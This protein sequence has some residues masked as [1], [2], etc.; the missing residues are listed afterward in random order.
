MTLKT[1]LRRIFKD[2]DKHAYEVI[3][4]I[5]AEIIIAQSAYNNLYRT[6]CD[7]SSK[8]Y[9][10]FYTVLN[11]CLKKDLNG[12]DIQKAL[13]KALRKYPDLLNAITHVVQ[14]TSK[15]R[16]DP[17][18]TLVL[19]RILESKARMKYH[20]YT[21]KLNSIVSLFFFYVFL[22]PIP[23]ILVSGFSPETSTILFSAFFIISMIV[24]R[25]FFDK[26]GRIRS[27]LLG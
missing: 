16:A 12:V 6:I 23:I 25:I 3:T 10:E 26:I 9:E 19:F 24:F 15:Q 21:L 27:V 1:F 8:K 17:E 22:V 4:P 20:E 7:V 18:E 14:N 11:Q 13:N 2:D 5:V